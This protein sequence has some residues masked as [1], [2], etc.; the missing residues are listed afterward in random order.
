MKIFHDC[1][2]D[3]LALHEFLHCCIVN[4]YDTSATQTYRN[5]LILYEKI[6]QM[7]L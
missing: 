1:R 6:D 5:Q 3:S 4:V 2:H 7:N